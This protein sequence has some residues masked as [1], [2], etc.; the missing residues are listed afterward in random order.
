MI[1][2]F[3]KQQNIDA[4]SLNAIYILNILL[5]TLIFFFFFL[6]QNYNESVDYMLVTSLSLFLSFSFS[7]NYRQSLLADNDI[8]LC[9]QVFVK[10]LF[11][12]IIIFIASFL[13]S[14]FFL[15]INDYKIIFIATFIPVVI[16]L[17]EINLII[18]EIKKKF[19]NLFFK[20]L[21]NY[22]LLLFLF[23]SFFF[24][25]KNLIIF[26]I[27]LYVIIFFFQSY[28][29]E[30]NYKFFFLKKLKLIFA[31]N[32]LSSLCLQLSSFIF[33]YEINLFLEKKDTAFIFFTISVGSS[34]ATITFN[35]IGPKDF[36][37]NIK[38]TV[39]FY[40]LLFIYLI[41]CLIL[42]LLISKGL[43]FKSL[44]D[45]KYVFLASIIG[46]LIFVFSYIYRQNILSKI[47][48]RNH[49]FYLDIF[50]SIIVILSVPLLYFFNKNYL[51]Y[52]YLFTSACSFVIFYFYYYLVFK[53]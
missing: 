38:L 29:F 50:F 53:K 10:R 5:P 6:S 43:I 44:F 3:L 1:N 32:Y 26:I 34:L 7:G 49:T 17:N 31:L 24:F 45:A 11:I 18:I 33:K 46:G 8:D 40:C 2:Y 48:Y 47:Q 15:K 39:K 19:K 37:K 25:E 21:I 27:S 23:L 22:I 35:S 52:S 36:C 14:I 16:W 51:M 28:H 20:F 42:Y 4:I 12:G 30:L 41:V 13:I 9:E